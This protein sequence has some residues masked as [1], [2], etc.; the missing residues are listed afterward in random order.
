MSQKIIRMTLYFFIITFT[1]FSLQYQLQ[2]FS[3]WYLNLRT[4]T[5]NLIRIK[6]KTIQNT[7]NTFRW[8]DWTTL[9]GYTE[10]E[11]TLIPVVFR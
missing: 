3:M 4:Y 5:V 11:I 9:K 7:V 10:K 8:M 6:N 1:L 2:I